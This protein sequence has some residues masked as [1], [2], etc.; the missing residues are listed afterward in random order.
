MTRLNTDD[1]LYASTPAIV[2][3]HIFVPL[4]C[5]FLK[6][7][8][9]GFVYSNAK[10]KNGIFLFDRCNKGSSQIECMS[11]ERTKAESP[12]KWLKKIGILGPIF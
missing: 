2:H 8:S 1:E 4:R 6:K 5:V 3:T 11:Y 10:K 12:P 7:F 9:V